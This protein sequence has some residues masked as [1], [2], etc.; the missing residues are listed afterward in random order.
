MPTPT[1]VEIVLSDEE[2]SVLESWTA[3]RKTAQA[4][5]LRA[6]IVL[7]AAGQL[8]NR[9]IASELFVS[10]NTLKTHVK[11]IYG[12]LGVSSRAEAVAE[13]RRLGVL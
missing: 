12:K 1:A 4:L 10:T 7:A 5:A 9:E 2:R 8:T 3:R 11:R 13:A 6:R